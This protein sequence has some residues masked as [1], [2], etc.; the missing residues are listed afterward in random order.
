MAKL[1]LMS[2]LICNVAIP[3][4]FAASPPSKP[5]EAMI[6]NIE[7]WSN[8][9]DD[10]FPTRLTVAR[11]GSA[12]LEV[13]SNDGD[14]LGPNIGHFSMEL[15]PRAFELLA[16]AVADTAFLQHANPGPVEPGEVIRRMRVRFSN[17][18]EVRRFVQGSAP[19]DAG[20]ARAEQAAL[21]LA[22]ETRRH[23]TDALALAATLSQGAG[24]DDM[25]IDVTITNVGSNAVAVPHPDHWAESGM[26]FHLSVRRKDVPLAEMSN[27]HQTFLEL[28]RE[29]LVSVPALT[30]AQVT[31]QPGQ[32]QVLS[33]GV[34]LPLSPGRYEAWGALLVRLFA[35]NG[36]AIM[37]GELLSTRLPIVR[38]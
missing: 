4:K 18:R 1:L 34:H 26:A 29:A 30:A 16:K 3:A 14:P 7:Y 13:A 31:I 10:T 38:K 37:L 35:E 6:E 5:K 20:F 24:R 32:R 28:G 12:E 8:A 9:A 25:V 33:F 19:V 27:E 21:R 36:N 17:G 2:L 22:A 15:E 23:P 11:S